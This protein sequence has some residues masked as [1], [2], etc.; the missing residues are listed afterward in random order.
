MPDTKQPIRS[1]KEG[2]KSYMTENL[3]ALSRNPR[4]PFELITLWK[5][6]APTLLFDTKSNNLT[7]L[8]KSDLDD[9]LL[10]YCFVFWKR[11]KKSLNNNIKTFKKSRFFFFIFI[12]TA[13]PTSVYSWVMQMPLWDS[14]DICFGKYVLNFIIHQR[15][16][17]V[18]D[19]SGQW[20]DITIVDGAIG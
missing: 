3:P 5:H 6:R 8:L 19:G 11:K 10:L 1:M 16:R 20:W 7:D 9:F 17:S 13:Y 14:V 4:E 15:V 18:I 2:F 12:Q